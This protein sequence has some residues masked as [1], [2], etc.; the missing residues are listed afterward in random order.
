MHKFKLIIF[1]FTL[2]ALFCTGC[3]YT[4]SSNPNSD[5]KKYVRLEMF[6]NFTNPYQPG[7][8]NR[9]FKELSDELITSGYVLITNQTKADV[10]VSGRILEH[11]QTVLSTS[12]EQN[13]TEISLT[14]NIRVHFLHKSGRTESF[15]IKSQQE[16]FAIV[17]GEKLEKAEQRTLQETSRKIILLLSGIEIPLN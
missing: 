15:V 5:Y 6:E 2:S 9:L 4:L 10:T 8:E 1:T 14:I 11:A 17:L 13:P 3:G 7:L 12:P 16:P